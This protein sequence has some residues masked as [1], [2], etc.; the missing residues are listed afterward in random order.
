[1]VIAEGSACVQATRL[2]H[3]YCVIDFCQAMKGW[4]LSSYLLGVGWVG[5][6]RC[7]DT[8]VKKEYDAI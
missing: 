6:V 3:V 7:A 2:K 1:V 4:F 5:F 8:F